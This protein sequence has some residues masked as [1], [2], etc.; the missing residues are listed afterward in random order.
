MVLISTCNCLRGKV[1]VSFPGLFN[2]VSEKEDNEYIIG[3]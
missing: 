2:V 1:N 3:Y